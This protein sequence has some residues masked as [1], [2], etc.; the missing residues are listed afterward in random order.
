MTIASRPPSLGGPMC[1][2]CHL[3]EVAA[4]AANTHELIVRLSDGYDTIVGERGNVS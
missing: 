4:R 3:I 2:E 1:R